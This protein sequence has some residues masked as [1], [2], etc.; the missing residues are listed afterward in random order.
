MK[1]KLP[2]VHLIVSALR[3]AAV[4]W[5]VGHLHLVKVHPGEGR[6]GLGVVIKVSDVAFGRW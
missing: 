4:G 6:D 3:L 5:L 2:K 1:N